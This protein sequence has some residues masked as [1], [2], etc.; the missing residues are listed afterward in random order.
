MLKKLRFGLGPKGRA[1][2]LRN[3]HEFFADPN[4]KEKP[5]HVTMPVKDT[6]AANSS[7][8]VSES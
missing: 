7:I 1:L 6:S 8:T 4:R 3:A 5:T 2:S